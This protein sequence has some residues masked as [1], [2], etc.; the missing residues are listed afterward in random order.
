MNGK[1]F[2]ELMC[3]GNYHV[4]VDVC[5]MQTWEK[6]RTF[7]CEGRPKEN[8]LLLYVSKCEVIYRM[9]S[10]EEIYAGDGDIVFVPSGK[11][12][13]LTV[14]SRQKDGC[15]YGINFLTFD[16]KNMRAFFDGV[17]VLCRN[18]ESILSL[19]KVMS[20]ISESGKRSYGKLQCIFYRIVLAVNESKRAFGRFEVI[21]SGI[22][23]MENDPYL[24]KSV[25]ES[26]QMCN[27]SH[28]WFCRLFREYAGIPPKE[29][30]L[31]VKI[32]KAKMLLAE[33]SMSVCEIALLCGFEDP[34]YFSRIYKKKV[35]CSPISTKGK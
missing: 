29:Y 28:N 33:T 12:Y 9:K 22:K 11:E 16:G 25:D 5:V 4:R 21:E 2:S 19:F 20:D 8:D 3:Y 24:T 15:T 31:D 30:I 27:V 32:K 6:Y 34:A 17:S 7:S 18:S 10:G 23:Y 14:K 13:V 1:D 26:A 35:G